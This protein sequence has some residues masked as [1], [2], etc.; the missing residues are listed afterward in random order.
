VARLVILLLGV[1]K[2]WM[3]VDAVRRKVDTHWYYLILFVP[4][5]EVAYFFQVKLKD[6]GVHFMTRRLL[7]SLKRPPTVP[8]LEREHKRTPSLHNRTR[9]AQGVF[10]AGA[11]EA[12]REHFEAVLAQ[13]PDDKA[14]RHG[15]ACCHIELGDPALAIPILRQLLDDHPQYRDYEPWAELV[16]A[17]WRTD[18]RDESLVLAAELVKRSPRLRHIVLHAGYLRRAGRHDE[19]R[20]A[21]REALDE[22]QD[23]P[24]HVRRQNRP[25]ARQAK[26]MLHDIASARVESASDQ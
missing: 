24:R 20:E 11:F 14:A 16:D 3:F 6:P 15:I 19:A 13:Q 8:E 9:L 2:A 10:D 26:Q 23:A 22:E 18:E 25:F 5:G 4:L 21:L 12:A 17:L 7:E 1:L